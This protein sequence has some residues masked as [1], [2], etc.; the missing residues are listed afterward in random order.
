MLCALCWVMWLK[1]ILSKIRDPGVSPSPC[2]LISESSPSGNQ[3]K[4]IFSGM[5]WK[6]EG[7]LPGK[8]QDLLWDTEAERMWEC[9]SMD[10]L[11]GAKA[12]EGRDQDGP[13]RKKE[14]ENRW[15]RVMSTL[16]AG[17]MFVWDLHHNLPCLI[18]KSWCSLLCCWTH[19]CEPAHGGDRLQ[20]RLAVSRMGGLVPDWDHQESESPGKSLRQGLGP[21]DQLFPES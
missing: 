4:T 16:S 11:A 5:P 10:Y 13:G 20:A 15:K 17:R 18:P 1:A 8:D 14:W 19:Y 12:A 2:N 7:F 21:Q 9:A 3:P 6:L